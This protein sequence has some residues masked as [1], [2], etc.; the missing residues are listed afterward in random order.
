MTYH[1]ALTVGTTGMLAACT[2]ALLESCEQMTCLARTRRSLE[3]LEQRVSDPKK[4]HTVAT[5]YENAA[6]FMGEVEGAWQR[7]A[8]DLVLVWM[9]SSGEQSLSALL[10]FLAK[11]TQTVDFFHVVGSAVADPSREGET[12]MLAQGASLRYHRIIL[13]FQPTPAG[14]RWLTNEE[15]SAGTL[16]AV[17]ERRTS[18]VVGTVTPWS[19]RP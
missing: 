16:R 11:Q 5:D 3:N 7:R 14:S 15:I 1:H 19:A 4:L 10:D 13:G 8:F 2:A 18:H 17:R 6:A 12:Q 9:H